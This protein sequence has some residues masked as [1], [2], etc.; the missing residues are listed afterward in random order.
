MKPIIA[1]GIFAFTSAILPFLTSCTDVENAPTSPINHPPVLFEIGDR[2]ISENEELAFRIMAEDPEGDSIHFELENLPE[3][4]EFIGDT[5]FWTPVFDQAGVYGGIIFR[6]WDDGQPALS[7]EE[8]IVINVNDVNRPP[9]WISVAGGQHDLQFDEGALIAFIARGFDPDSTEVEI[10]FD[11]DSLPEVASF[12]IDEE[13][14]G[15]GY[16]LWQ[17]NNDDRG[18]YEL[19]FTI[20]DGEYKDVWEVFI[21]IG[22]INRPPRWIDCPDYCIADEGELVEIS[23]QASDPDG[24]SLNLSAHSDSLTDGWNFTDN[25]N[26][27]GDFSWQT[28]STDVGGHSLI[29]IA[30]DGECE[31]R[32]DVLILVSR[33]N[34]PPHWID[35]PDFILYEGDSLY[36]K[37]EASDP[38]GDSMTLSAYSDSLNDGWNF[39]DN[40]DG[41]GDFN[42]QTDSTDVGCH[43]LSLIV[44]DGEYE[45]QADIGI[46]VIR[47]NRPPPLINVPNSVTGVAGQHIGFEVQI[48]EDEYIFNINASS[49]DLPPG[50]QFTD[51]GNNYAEFAWT[52]ADDD[53]GEYTVTVTIS[54]D[55]Y[56]DYLSETRDVRIFVEAE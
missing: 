42:W 3:G 10:I 28:D 9:I 18:S 38:D 47:I 37:F 15:T 56:N 12:T 24:D 1:C 29:L 51:Y 35:C 31:V 13:D 36:Y 49:N 5:F 53:V 22:N 32:A 2:E 48:F 33:V 34:R 19:S 39:T 6:V 8:T 17:T 44:S 23:F 25:G 43:T 26:G 4:A 20:M 55:Y 16:F 7:D 46:V 52:P 21:A 11:H 27:S 54:G 30:S 40:G 41:T 50:W 45:I 14:P